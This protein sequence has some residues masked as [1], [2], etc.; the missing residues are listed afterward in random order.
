MLS[1]PGQS[2]CV[3]HGRCNNKTCGAIFG[4]EQLDFSVKIENKER[5]PVLALCRSNSSKFKLCLVWLLWVQR[6]LLV[7]MRGRSVF[8]KDC[9]P[10]VTSNMSTR[11]QAMSVLI[12]NH[13]VRKC[14]LKLANLWRNNDTNQLKNNWQ[15]WQPKWASDFFSFSRSF[16]LF[17]KKANNSSLSLSSS[18]IEILVK[19]S[20]E[21]SESP[22]NSSKLPL[23]TM[24]PKLVDNKEMFCI[25]RT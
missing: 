19:V 18:V 8:S 9:D 14:V 24:F 10:L 17:V 11:P 25:V 22:S 20:C 2:T 4:I 3:L 6:N 16:L 12:R 13:Q 5:K 15:I 1:P 23:V 21:N 7:S